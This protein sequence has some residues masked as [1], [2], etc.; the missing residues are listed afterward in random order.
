MNHRW[1]R[2]MLSVRS[3]YVSEENIAVTIIKLEFVCQ[4]S[5]VVLFFQK[6]TSVLCNASFLLK[7]QQVVT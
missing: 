7:Q 6:C 2:V 1:K 5:T 4:T 3:L